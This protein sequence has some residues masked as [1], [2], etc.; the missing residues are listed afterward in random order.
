[1][2]KM[3]EARKNKVDDDLLDIIEEDDDNIDI[4]DEL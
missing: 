2:Q 1:M 4:D 3:H